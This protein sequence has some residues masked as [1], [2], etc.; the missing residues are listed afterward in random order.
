[1]LSSDCFTKEG[2]KFTVSCTCRAG[3]HGQSCRHRLNILAGERVDIVSENLE[4][5]ATV[6]SW[7]P[8]SHI[9]S[10]L[11]EVKEAEQFA[12]AAKRK[13]SSAKTRHSQVMEYG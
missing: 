3:Q 7:L 9:E 13:L 6:Q 8:G 10:A 4:D 1:M 2:E 11:N 5:V 12:D